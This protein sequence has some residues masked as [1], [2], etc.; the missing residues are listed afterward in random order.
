[1]ISQSPD[2]VFVPVL[3]LTANK[4]SVFPTWQA[5]AA[6]HLPEINQSNPE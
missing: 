5:P 4:W 3:A 1:M 6:V 2:T